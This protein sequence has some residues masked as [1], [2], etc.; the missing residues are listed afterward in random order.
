MT[1][2][3]LGMFVMGFGFGPLW[4]NTFDYM[5]KNLS[6]SSFPIY[7]AVF[8]LSGIIGPGFGYIFG[9]LLLSLPFD[10]VFKTSEAYSS[11]SDSEYEA[12]TE[13]TNFIGAY[14]VG[15]VFSAVGL[16]LIS[17]PV[18]GF[19]YQFPESENI[20]HKKVNEAFGATSLNE[21]SK[22]TTVASWKDFKAGIIYVIKNP[23]VICIA[24]A[25]AMEGFFLA[26]MSS[27][28]PKLL[29][30][31]FNFTSSEAALTIGYILIP[32]ATIALI[33]GGVLPKVCS[34]TNRHLLLFCFLTS[35][36]TFLSTFGF[37]INGGQADFIKP[38]DQVTYQGVT[39]DISSCDC[40]RS[41][42]KPFCLDKKTL[43]FSP[44]YYGCSDEVLTN[45]SCYN[46]TIN[47][48]LT[49]GSCEISEF[50][51]PSNFYVMLFFLTV[52]CFTVFFNLPAAEAALD[53]SVVPKFRSLAFGFDVFIMRFFGTVPATL[54]VGAMFDGKCTLWQVNSNGDKGACL[55]YDD[56]V[57]SG[58]TAICIATT[59]LMSL[60]FLAAFLFEK[61]KR[62]KFIPCEIGTKHH[63]NKFPGAN[64]TSDKPIDAVDKND[65]NNSQNYR[66]EP[67]MNRDYTQKQSVLL[68]V[69]TSL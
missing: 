34:F 3:Y 38:S 68:Q 33:L 64:S 62:E 13:N 18:G 19:P 17:I 29:Q 66:P 26:S 20:R 52:G 9:G 16:F 65:N 27:F 56:S 41:N 28:G 10:D 12:L 25:G 6:H 57:A 35:V 24:F 32:S 7:S 31:L 30:V 4:T 45:C 51:S 40:D 21:E 39:C 37:F 53:R 2:F 36:T 23:I 55:R 63:G 49:S 61:F 1:L 58:F 60:L 54:V 42:F 46:S 8:T 67:N 47:S 22:L 11:M 5:D 69:N 44:C 50:C 59:G 48:E 14:W 15:F 43:I